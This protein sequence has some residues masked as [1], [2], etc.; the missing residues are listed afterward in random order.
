MKEIELEFC[1]IYSRNYNILLR[2]KEND[3]YEAGIID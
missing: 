3:E 1:C 2:I